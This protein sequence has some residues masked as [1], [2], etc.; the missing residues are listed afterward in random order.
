MNKIHATTQSKTQKNTQPMHQQVYQALCDSILAGQ[1]V[2]GVSVTLR[3]IAEQLGVSSMPVREAIR[4]LVAEHALQVLSNRRVCV[5]AMTQTRLQELYHAR[6]SLE[7][8]LALL[9]MPSIGK[10]EIKSL[11]HIDDELD[12]SLRSGNVD[13]Y[14]LCNR[15]FHFDIYNHADSPVLYPLVRSLWLQFAPFMRI[16]F[17]RMGTESIQDFHAD[18]LLALQARDKQ[19]FRNAIE[20][21]IREGMDL[22]EEHLNRDS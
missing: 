6:L 18:A 17:G 4:R 20:S 21:D 7:P 1:F 8:E 9:A 14:I 5:T 19:A 15:R 11:T 12:L 22:L 10:S 2:P 16:V 3:G 13:A